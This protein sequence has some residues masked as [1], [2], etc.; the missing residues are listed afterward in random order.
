MDWLKDG[1]CRRDRLLPYTS[2]M[3]KCK[4]RNIFYRIVILLACKERQKFF[5]KQINITFLIAKLV[6]IYIFFLNIYTYVIVWF[7]TLLNWWGK[8]SLK[9]KHVVSLSSERKL[10]FSLANIEILGFL[11]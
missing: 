8:L 6:Y 2:D 7:G 1:F 9:F 3:N 4:K 10:I 5:G 11:H